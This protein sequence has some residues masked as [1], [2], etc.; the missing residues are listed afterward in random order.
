[1]KPEEFVAGAAGLPVTDTLRE[2]ADAIHKAGRG[3]LF[4]YADAKSTAMKDM[5]ADDF[6]K[7]LNAGGC[8]LDAPDEKATVAQLPTV[9]APTPVAEDPDLPLVVALDRELEPGSPILSKLYRESNLRLG[10]HCVAL[11]PS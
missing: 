4:A 2:R 10:P 6:W 8:W 9:A 5:S 3:S 1:M 11:H 7:A